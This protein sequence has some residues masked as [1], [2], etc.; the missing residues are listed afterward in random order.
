VLRTQYSYI[1]VGKLHLCDICNCAIQKKLPFSLSTLKVVFDL[2]H[3]NIWVPYSITS[4]Q[5]FRYCL[6]IVD[7]F[8]RYTLTYLLHAK[9]EVRQH[10]VNFIAY[11]ENQ[12]H[13][14]AKIIRTNNGLKFAMKYIFSSKGIIHQTTCVETPEQNDIVERNINIY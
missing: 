8:S 7:D 12:F 2:V 6:T 13:T 9:S 10:I 11:I 4:M 5:G 1:S 3:M 14:T